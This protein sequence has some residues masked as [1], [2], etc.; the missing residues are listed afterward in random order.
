[1]FR[2]W[3]CILLTA[4][5]LASLASAAP[6]WSAK[7][8]KVVEL[9]GEEARYLAQRAGLWSLLDGEGNILQEDFIISFP[10]SFENGVSFALGA[11]DLYCYLLD[12]G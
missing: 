8:E 9:K 11:N 6:A 2:R 5:L 3:I 12:T 10:G 1:M 4:L 7:W